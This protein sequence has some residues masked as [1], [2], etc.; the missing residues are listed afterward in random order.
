M[1]FEFGEVP[2]TLNEILIASYNITADTYGVPAGMMGDQMLEVN[3]VADTDMLR[4]SGKITRLLARSTHAE[5][6]IGA[7]GFDW[8][9]IAIL[10]GASTSTSGTTPNQVRTATY[11]LDLPYFGAIGVASTDDGGVMVV[12]LR[13][14]KLD[15][16]F[17][18]TFDGTANKFMI[19]DDLA[20]KAIY[21][22]NVLDEV[23]VYETESDWTSAKPTDGTEF[24]AFFSA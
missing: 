7:G 1:A 23:V 10:S 15:K 11:S 8:N 17:K 16:R 2:Y 19:N 9:V 22:G 14:A 4:D 13:C 5:I 12:G 6:N 21:V 18:Y 20:G 3:P 24:K